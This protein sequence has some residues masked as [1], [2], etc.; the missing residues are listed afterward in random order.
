[1]DIIALLAQKGGT[2]KTT[3]A[4][5]LAVAAVKK[6]KRVV[7]LDLDPQASATN[8]KD[9]RKAKAPATFS[10]QPSRL[11]QMV[12]AARSKGVDL[13]IIDTP[14][15]S[16]SASLA[17][18]KAADLVIIPCRPQIYD[19][20][21]IPA[22]KDIIG[23]AGTK[24]AM[25]VLN[26]VNVQ[27]QRHIEAS[28][29]IRKKHDLPVAPFLFVQRAAFGDAPNEGLTAQEL[30]PE[31][32]AAQEIS[33]LYNFIIQ[34]FQTLKKEDLQNLPKEEPLAREEQHA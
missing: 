8:W 16:E 28:N 22:T 23:L 30:E 13:L 29:I 12:E 1:M 20:E 2:G 3:L 9:R 4:L 21:T 27:G 17:A 25:V 31:G 32:K 34:I 7:I 6:G 15:K 26:A 11:T 5:S 24:R 19:L 14:P 10:V 18:A 33:K